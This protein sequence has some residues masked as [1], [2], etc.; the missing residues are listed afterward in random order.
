MYTCL[1]LLYIY[2]CTVYIKY[3]KFSQGFTET[4]HP[5][6]RT[7]FSVCF[8]L[9]YKSSGDSEIEKKKNSSC[10]T[11]HHQFHPSDQRTVGSNCKHG[12]CVSDR[13]REREVHKECNSPGGEQVTLLEITGTVCTAASVFH[14]IFRESYI[15]TCAPLQHLL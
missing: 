8:C 7:G 3:R 10:E 2:G 12:L 15:W 4:I 5:P 11:I 9:F 6:C 13:Q 14:S 1:H